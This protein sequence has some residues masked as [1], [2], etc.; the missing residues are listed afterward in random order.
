MKHFRL[1]SIGLLLLTLASCRKLI[2]IEETDFIGG[3]IALKTVN[4]NEQGIVGA[5]AGMNVEMGI[6]LNS[7]MTDEVKVAEFYNSATVHEW[8]FASTDVTI[9]DNFT[10]ITL[11]Y[12]IID[13]V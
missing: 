5:Y 7:V 1:L 10:A 11:Y 6:L 8:Q 9:R 12:R 3:D 13:R 4:N 2:E